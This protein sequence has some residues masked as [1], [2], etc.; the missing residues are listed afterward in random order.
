MN[1][2]N[3]SNRRRSIDGADKVVF[4]LVRLSKNHGRNNSI[5]GLPCSQH[6][7]CH[8][9]C[10]EHYEDAPTNPRYG[11]GLFAVQRPPNS[12][13]YHFGTSRQGLRGILILRAIGTWW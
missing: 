5:K 11:R 13:H 8:V 7:Q 2:S 6:Q 10:I 4:E 9:D 12:L 3:D 1:V